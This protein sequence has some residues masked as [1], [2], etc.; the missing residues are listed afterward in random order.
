MEV[1]T[2][3]QV[4]NSVSVERGPLVYALQIDN[5]YEV[6][7]SHP[8]KGFY[9]Y[10]I[11]PTESWNYGLLLNNS[12]LTTQ[13]TV[14]KYKMPDNPFDP[15]NTPVRLMVKAKEIPEWKMAYNGILAFEVPYSPLKSDK[16]IVEV[17]LIPSGAEKIRISCFPVIG[18]KKDKQKSFTANFDD[19]KMDDWVFYGGGWFVKDSAIS[20]ASNKGS[21]GAGIHGSKVIAAK[22]TASDFVF[23]TDISPGKVGNS[24]VIFRVNNP[25]I[26]PDLYE[27][28]YVGINPV[29]NR[30]EIGKSVNQNYVLLAS[31]P[32]IVQENKKYRLNVTAEGNSI[33]V[34]I[35]GNSKPVVSAK[36][37]DFKSGSVGL[38]SFDGLPVYDNISVTLR[39]M[40]SL[41]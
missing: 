24:G 32:L 18:A 28:Y 37:N 25:S 8:V 2:A 4:N 41:K 7:K 36:D 31:S 10:K 14:K 1:N 11:T 38:R 13:I 22:V 34:F 33:N 30:I 35:D 9:D 27:G 21:W 15:T 5:K 19:G 17:T 40:K 12:D 39:Q 20:A 3:Q 6:I 23:E 16:P 26:G 29:L